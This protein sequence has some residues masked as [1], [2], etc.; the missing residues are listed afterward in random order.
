[1]PKE[2]KVVATYETTIEIAQY[3]W[4]LCESHQPTED[5]TDQQFQ[6]RRDAVESCN[7]C[8]AKA[9]ESAYDEAYSKFSDA[10]EIEVI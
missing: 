10:D 9:W 8:D 2:Y 1:M 5:E 7:K 4:E 3:D 6:D